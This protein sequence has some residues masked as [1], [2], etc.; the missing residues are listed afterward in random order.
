MPQ[1]APS[2]DDAFEYICTCDGAVDIDAETEQ[3]YLKSH[4]VS[5]LKFKQGKAPIRWRLRPLKA[6]A[7]AHLLRREKPLEESDWLYALAQHGIDSVSDLPAGVPPI[8]YERV[9][10]RRFVSD[11]WMAN[12]PPGF[13]I[14]LGYQVQGVSFLDAETEKNLWWA[15]GENG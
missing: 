1:F 11:D 4:D 6:V 8:T 13:A 3:R 12:L 10:A 2:T 5:L 9:G 7:R 14:E 15:S